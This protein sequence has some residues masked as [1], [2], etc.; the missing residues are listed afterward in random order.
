[1]SVDK[2]E[3]K[4]RKNVADLML[5]I[6]VSLRDKYR[7]WSK[8][9]NSVILTASVFTLYISVAKSR[10]LEPLYLNDFISDV[11]VIILTIIILISSILSFVYDWSGKAQ[12]FE[13]AFRSLSELKS[14]WRHFL[15]GH[16][17]YSGLNPDD[18]LQKDDLVKRNLPP[19]PE[20][21]FLRLKS[22]HHLKEKLSDKV[23]SD[24]A[25]PVTLI[26]I[27]LFLRSILR[28]LNII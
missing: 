13:Q 10:F 1:M 21:H 3:I 20:S 23:A 14:G 17:T 5:T 9:L 6:C 28:S 25:M 8:I 12:S 16:D 11:V 4:R 7:F 15:E 22:W 18:F 19:I 2:D 24:P 27:K 26:R